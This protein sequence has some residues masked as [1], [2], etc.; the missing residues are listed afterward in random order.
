[1][2]NVPTSP[3]STSQRAQSS[4]ELSHRL[5]TGFWRDKPKGN[6]C[7]GA[8]KNSTRITT[9]AHATGAHARARKEGPSGAILPLS[10]SPLARS[11]SPA[12]L[13]WFPPALNA[14][15]SSFLFFPAASYFPTLT[16]HYEVACVHMSDIFT[17][18]SSEKTNR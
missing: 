14:F 4:Q 5:V 9:H 3:R 8:E 12:P 17:Y 15:I 2:K 13:T 18:R 10:C 7:H 6:I 11:C 16:G 1:M